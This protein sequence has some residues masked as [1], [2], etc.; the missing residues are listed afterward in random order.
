MSEKSTKQR[1]AEWI[2]NNDCDS[3]KVCAFFK[4][5]DERYAT[6]ENYEPNEQECVNGIINYFEDLKYKNEQANQE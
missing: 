6:D 5:C 1:M 3:C 2:Q 4:Q